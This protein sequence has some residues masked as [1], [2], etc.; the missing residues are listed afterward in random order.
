MSYLLN[1][2]KNIEYNLREIRDITLVPFNWKAVIGVYSP[3]TSKQIA[4][5]LKYFPC[6]TDT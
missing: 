1:N 4:V 6:L 2:K 5:E 3:K